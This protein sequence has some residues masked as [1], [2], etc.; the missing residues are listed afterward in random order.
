MKPALVLKADEVAQ[1]LEDKGVAEVEVEGVAEAEETG[2]EAEETGAEA[3][4]NAFSKRRSD[5][6]TVVTITRT[7]LKNKIRVQKQV[8]LCEIPIFGGAKR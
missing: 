4:E 3:E 7:Y 8:E 5:M 6:R 2:A 1:D